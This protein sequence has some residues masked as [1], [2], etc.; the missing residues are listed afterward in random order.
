MSA[1]VLKSSAKREGQCGIRSSKGIPILDETYSFIVVCT[2]KDEEYTSVLNATGLPYVGVTVSPSGYGVCKSKNAT[3]RTDNPY[4]WDV[5]STFSSEVE[6]KSDQQD[7]STDPTAWVPI[8]ETKFERLQ[9][10][11][12]KDLAGTSIA[13]S[14][15]QPFP[16]GLTINRF[17]PVWEFF[18]IE[19]PISDETLIDRNET[20]NSA[21]FK[22]RAAK[23]L[24]LTVMM[25]Q[26][27]FYYGARRRLTQ[28]SL[29]YNSRL[30]THKRLDVGTVYVSSGTHLPY[31]DSGT[32]PR[33]INGGLNGSGAKVSVGSPPETLVFEQYTQLAFAS[34]LRI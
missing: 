24:L 20:I 9:E 13:N 33:V 34:F 11:V 30:W 29:K 12:T 4:Y 6:E 15:G 32:P 25:S 1:S 26:V 17:I 31:L 21:V 7:P 14:A 10:I 18:Q 8:Y 28:Y 23:S 22:G 16:V 5:T 2:N 3:R 27:G 19:P